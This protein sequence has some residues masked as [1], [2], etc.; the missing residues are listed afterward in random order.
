MCSAV[1]G[2][3]SSHPCASLP[4]PTG[5]KQ[6]CPGIDPG[7]L[8]ASVVASMV[9]FGRFEVLETSVRI[10]TTISA[11]SGFTLRSGGDHRGGW[12]FFPG[13]IDTARMPDRPQQASA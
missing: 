3:V 8:S 4:A 6:I 10:R 2:P 5:N 13:W 9:S 11:L 7:R 1:P 12:S